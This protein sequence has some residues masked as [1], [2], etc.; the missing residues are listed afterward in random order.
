M[1]DAGI[2]RMA[3]VVAGV[4]MLIMATSPLQ[5]LLDKPGLIHEYCNTQAIYSLRDD[6]YGSYADILQRYQK[7]LNTGVY[8][9]D[10]GWKNVSHYL[11]PDSRK[12]LWEFSNAIKEFR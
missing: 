7:Q 8:W 5:G 9:A 6:G 3:P 12:G 11:V 4:K 2:L 1:L 10:R